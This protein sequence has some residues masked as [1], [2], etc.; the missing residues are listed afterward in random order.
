M[1]LPITTDIRNTKSKDIGNFSFQ[2]AAFIAAGVG[3]GILTWKLTDSYEIA[4]APAFLI[5]IF[6][7]FK[8]FGMSMWTFIGLFIRE[9]IMTPKNMIY[10]DD[11]EFDDETT[12]LFQEDGYDVS[13]VEYAIQAAPQK[14]KWSKEDKQRIAR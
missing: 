6:G 14:Y 9:K 8:P 12:K 1:E 5:L 4:I 7:F 2:Q 11:F 10:E 3:T 13:E